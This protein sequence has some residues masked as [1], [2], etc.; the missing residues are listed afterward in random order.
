M[1]QG[2]AMRQ[3][4]VLFSVV[5]CFNKLQRVYLALRV[6]GE[7]EGLGFVGNH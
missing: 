4:G 6:R 1:R 7:A 5:L 2:A 3:R